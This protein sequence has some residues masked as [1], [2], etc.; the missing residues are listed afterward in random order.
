M[1]I[2]IGVESVPPMTATVIRLAIGAVVVTLIAF[3]NGAK[4]PS[5]RRIWIVSIAVG[6]IGNAIPFS[7]IQ[8][9]EQTIDS[10]LAALLMGIMPIVV[11]VLANF[12]TDEPLTKTRLTGVLIAFAGLTVLVGWDIVQQLGG[13]VVAQIA[14]LCAATCYAISAIYVRRQGELPMLSV[15]AGSLL[16][17]GLILTPIALWVEQPDLAAFTTDSLLAVFVLGLFQTGIAAIIYF[18]LIANLGAAVFSQVNYIVPVLGLCWGIVL[19]GERP[20][21]REGLALLTILVGLYLV[22]RKKGNQA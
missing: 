11:V 12:Y 2:K 18:R 10:G 5:S 14:V 9:G 8:W 22:N 15:A 19:L 21:W 1:L 3:A 13:D 7:L 17:G 16:T 4:L 6:L 20:G